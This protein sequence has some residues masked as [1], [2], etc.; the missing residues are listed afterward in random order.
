[1]EEIT[2]RY[3]L[4]QLAKSD[5]YPF[6][7][8]GH[9]RMIQDGIWKDIS[10]IDITEIDGFDNLHQAQDILAWEQNRI[11]KLY[12]SKKS[13]ILV[14]GSTCGVLAAICATCQENEEILMARNSHKSAYHAVY[15]QRLR[16][17][18]LLPQMGAEEYPQG[19]IDVTTVKKALEKTEAKVVFLTS[20]TYEGVISDIK[21]IADAVHEKNGILIVDEAHGAHLKFDSRFGISAVDLGADLVI[22][23][24]HKTLPT[25]TQ[26]AVLHVCSDR[27]DMESIKRYLSIFQTSS[28]SYVLMASISDCMTILQKNGKELFHTYF[29]RLNQFYIQ[30]KEL[31]HLKVL[32]TNWAEESYGLTRDLSKIIIVTDH[33]MDLEGNPFH[34]P[35]LYKILRE[36]YHL[37]M[38]MQ[39]GDYVLAMTSI[40]DTEEA[41]E[42]FKQALFQIDQTLQSLEELQTYDTKDLRVS[43]IPKCA[44]RIYEAMN[45]RKTKKTLADAIGFVSAEYLYFY[46]PGTPILVPGECIESDLLE[47][48]NRQK[49]LGLVVQ[50]LADESSQTISVCELPD[51]DAL[52]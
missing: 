44:C 32:G 42:R 3:K 10:R 51:E 21:K 50:G 22:Q 27:V 12:Q 19:G 7:M 18:Y 23:S 15:M 40:M 49:S 41:F 4:D 24:L 28:P 17:S 43:N 46:P 31:K 52:V 25:M 34:G 8:P 1:M 39:M 29:D 9:K 47:R 16:A 11:A 38:E 6:H 35:Q 30:M 36:K 48:I 37:Q 33:L 20:P 14:N 45:A 2:L 5:V 26:T 13:F